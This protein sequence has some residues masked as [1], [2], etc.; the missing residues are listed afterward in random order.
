[1]HKRTAQ[2]HSRYTHPATQ[3]CDNFRR[4]SFLALGKGVAGNFV[5]RDD[6]Q[7]PGGSTRELLGCEYI[8]TAVVTLC[9]R[10]SSTNPKTK[11]TLGTMQLTTSFHILLSAGAALA[12]LNEPCYGPG[13][14]AGAF[15]VLLPLP[16]STLRQL[17]TSQAFACVRP[18]VPHPVAHSSTVDV[19][20]TQQT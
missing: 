12:A 17:N 13:G 1:V 10:S 3:S 15:P 20:G 18:P 16:P 7:M 5:S 6:E 4:L 11:Q 9:S 19:R 2:N 14:I 8:E